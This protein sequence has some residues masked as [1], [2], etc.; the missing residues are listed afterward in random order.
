ME[1]WRFPIYGGPITVFL[2]M[3]SLATLFSIFWGN[4]FFDCLRVDLV[5]RIYAHVVTVVMKKKKGTRKKHNICTTPIH[6]QILRYSLPKR[7]ATHR[8]RTTAL[9]RI[10]SV[11]AGG[12]MNISTL[13][14]S[15]GSSLQWLLT[16][17]NFCS[18]R[19]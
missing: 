10:A 5:K 16:A 15:V 14:W 11:N 13:N 12:V 6:H 4:F 2:N 9:F 18:C 17:F 1:L 8:L 7:S 3:I 19:I